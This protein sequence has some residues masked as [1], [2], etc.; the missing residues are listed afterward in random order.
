MANTMIANKAK[1]F[2]GADAVDLDFIR[3]NERVESRGRIHAPISSAEILTK[4]KEK[5]YNLGLELVNE[6][7][8]LLKQ[9]TDKNGNVKG[10]DR[11]MYIAQIKN[12]SR[13]EYSLSCGFRNFSDKS[14]AFSSMLSSEIFVCENGVC[15]GI[16]KPSKMRHTIGN[17]NSNLIDDKIDMVF[18][19][20]LENAPK[21]HHQIDMMKGTKLTDELVGKFV[22][23]AIGSWG[24]DKEG[25]P[26]FNKNPLLGSANLDR[27]LADLENPERNDKNDDSVMRLMN[28][29]SHITSHSITN[30]N[31]SAMASHF[32]NNLIMKLIDPNFEMIGDI[33]DVEAED[34]TE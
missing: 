28:S 29:C 15:H 7:A 31:Q 9:T 24:V 14:L 8:A 19:G 10:G 13:P 6:K 30:P 3:A 16:I 26:R 12:E 34:I 33:V 11:Y 17:V 32:C 22:R 23:E 5:A 18:A 2:T 21:I 20:F 1:W 27:I 4:F 25:H